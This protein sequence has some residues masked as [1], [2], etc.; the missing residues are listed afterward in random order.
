MTEAIPPQILWAQRTDKVFVS[1][2]LDDVS[3]ENI[4]VNTEKLT[5][6]GKSRNK[7]YAVDLEF[8]GSIIPEESKQRKGG[9]EY[10]FEL[11]KKEDG[12]YWPRLLK[13]NKKRQYL[14]I[15]FNRWKDEDES[16]DEA[17]AGPGPG[18]PGYDDANLESMM[19]QM[20]GGMGGMGGMPGMGGMAGMMGGMG[21]MPGMGGAPSFDPDEDE[22]SDDSDDDDLPELE[23]DI[24]AAKKE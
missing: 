19:A 15:D 4:T 23:S 14:K 18:G 9:R 2:Q 16:D 20:G 7:N 8:N 11:K 21:G 1:I 13:D 10:F 5:F 6:S 22:I 12:P 3:D 24:A 17:G